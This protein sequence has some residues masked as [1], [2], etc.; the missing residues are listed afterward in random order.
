MT[1]NEIEIYSQNEMLK[2]NRDKNWP[3]VYLL[4]NK[5]EIYIGETTSI[6]TRLL[7]HSKSENKSKLND[8]VIISH[9]N[10]SKS[11]AYLI[12]SDLIN[13]AFADGSL[14]LI[15]K[16]MQSDVRFSTHD[17][18][19][20]N[21]YSKDL[22]KIWNKLV[23]MGIF[24]KNYNEISNDDLFKY[25]PM[26]QFNENQVDVIK[27]VTKEIVMEQNSY[28]DG[29]AGT[30]KTLIVIRIAM[31]W[32]EQNLSNKSKIGIYT[33]KYGNFKTFKRVIDNLDKFYKNKIF[34]MRD[35]KKES[36]EKVEYLLIDEA[37]RLRK[38]FI[39]NIKGSRPPGYF[40]DKSIIDEIDWIT[41][42]KKSMHYF[43]IIDNLFI[44]EI[45]L[46]KNM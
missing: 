18:Y 35:L 3:V 11:V 19:N 34:V 24:K 23:Q 20:K 27:S 12:E 17:F 7:K 2:I 45:C 6:S 42:N 15:N 37:Q 9:P 5:K 1:R 28:V 4:R 41:K 25:S 36:L 22:P 26:K 46:W 30:G 33:A 32:A 44:K 13:R 40:K 16:K 14:N 29:A 21:E 43:L 10:S 39:K 8:K 31:N 38:N